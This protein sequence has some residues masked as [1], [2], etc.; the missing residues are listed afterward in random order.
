M[1]ENAKVVM[2]E[3][4]EERSQRKLI[5]GKKE[6]HYSSSVCCGGSQPYIVPSHDTS[7]AGIDIY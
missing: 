3:S 5:S 7:I 4:N 2:V 1:Y 6:P